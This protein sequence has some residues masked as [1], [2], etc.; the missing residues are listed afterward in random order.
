[1]KRTYCPP[2]GS[3]GDRAVRALRA[4]PMRVCELGQALNLR[5]DRVLCRIKGALRAGV[6]VR[7]ERDGISL[8][9]TPTPGQGA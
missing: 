7:V 9:L 6:I 4:G 5:T 3:Y 8:Y 1:M 2:P